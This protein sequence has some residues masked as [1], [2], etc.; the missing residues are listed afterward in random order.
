MT[1]YEEI[2]QPENRIPC[3]INVRDDKGMIA[4]RQVLDFV[5]CLV[6][7]SLSRRGH[8]CEI[9]SFVNIVNRVVSDG[10]SA[11]V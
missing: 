5:K 2:V 10:L 3:A 4:K 11:G 1:V 9:F 6:V 8:R 7:F